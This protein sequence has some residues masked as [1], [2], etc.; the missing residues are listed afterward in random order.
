MEKFTK[1]NNFPMAKG[2][3]PVIFGKLTAHSGSVS[4]YL[5]QTLQ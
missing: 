1:G 5:S 2:Y 4:I 3:I